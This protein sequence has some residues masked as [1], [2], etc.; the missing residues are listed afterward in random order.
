MGTL[1]TSAVL[2]CLALGAT[3]TAAD[4]NVLRVDDDRVQCPAADFTSLVDAVAAASQGD[5]IRVC[6][7]VYPVP[8][9]VGSSGLKIEKNL[10]LL[11]AGA[12]KVFVQ[13]DGSAPSTAATTPN[14]RDEF[15][16]VI[17]VK[18]RL[19]ELSDVQISGLTVR[20]SGTAVEAGIAMIDVNESRIGDVRVTGIAPDTGPGT[21]LF[22]GPMASQGHG[23]VLAN[24]IEG[25]V[26]AATVERVAVDGFNKAGIVVDSRTL[27]GTGERTNTMRATI[28]DSRITGAGTSP[29]VAQDGVEGWG[30]STALVLSRTLVTGVAGPTATPGA[31]AGVYLRGV[32][33]GSVVGGVR[34]ASNTI[35][36]NTFGA[37][38]GTFDGTAPAPVAIDARSNYWGSSNGPSLPPTK[39]GGDFAGAGAPTYGAGLTTAPFLGTAPT[40]PVA[41]GVAPDAA[42]T[43]RF[44]TLTDGTKVV[45]G[46]TVPLDVV[47]DD[48]FGVTSVAFA[49]DG[50]PLTS[51]GTFP[52]EADW[53]P[54]A[55]DDGAV[56]R[57]TAVVTDSAGR[58]TEVTARV[59]VGDLPVPPEPVTPTTPVPPVVP[60]TPD[61]P[62]PP[63]PVTPPVPVVPSKAP[64][65]AAPVVSK[66]TVRSSRSRK[67]LV[68][69]RCGATKGSA[70]CKGVLRL[71]SGRRR[72]GSRSFSIR[73]G[74][75]TAVTVTLS[76]SAYELLTRRNRLRA[77]V[78]LRARD[79]TGAL[80]ATTARVTLLP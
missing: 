51:V 78:T 4:A 48:D 47:A 34:T 5:T 55:A 62:A 25:T 59:Q 37:W 44:D 1:S 20:G 28:S 26:N 50:V 3:A 14:E 17:T 72:L 58:T 11:G 18:R 79:S 33:P 70:S 7:G 36:G 77:S 29:L 67:V 76:R 22:V 32:D 40:A 16:N 2:A 43:G 23:I 69:V 66:S 74:R 31:G 46:D 41:P 19:V 45:V 57:V 13:P 12:D 54:A 9:G 24:T 71:E 53:V 27:A 56:H 52:Y 61:V 49:V 60:A 8:G 39:S 64:T 68:R 30:R 65:P 73:A 35:S 38:A 80:R 6:D 63:G 75:T 21:G 42:P 10:K 15:G